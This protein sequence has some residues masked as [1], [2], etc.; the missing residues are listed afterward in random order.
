MR[1]MMNG[2]MAGMWIWWLVGLLQPLR[3]LVAR[4]AA[5]ARENLGEI[6]VA[7]RFALR[8]VASPGTAS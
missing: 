1:D 3:D 6:K 7:T 5:P 4:N 8:S 2:M